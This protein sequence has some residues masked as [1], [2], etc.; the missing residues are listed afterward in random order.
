[1]PTREEKL[2]TIRDACV[3]INQDI[4]RL[5]IGCNVL[6]FGAKK[7]KVCDVKNYT[8]KGVYIV[9]DRYGNTEFSPNEYEILG[10][11]IRLA[12]VLLVVHGNKE[13]VDVVIDSRGRFGDDNGALG[14]HDKGVMWNLLKDNLEEQ[15]DETIDF[16]YHL[17]ENK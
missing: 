7:R 17:I 2:K 5:D 9:V 13:Y 12:D 1:M 11:D 10:R 14:I 15:S 16:I 8:D 4:M 6:I 3:A